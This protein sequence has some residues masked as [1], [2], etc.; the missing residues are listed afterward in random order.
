MKTNK[1]FTFVFACIPG[2][3]HMYLGMMKKGILL[4]SI[5]M[6]LGGITAFMGMGFFLSFLPV[7]WFYA[8]FDTYIMA[9]AELEE[10]RERDT[11][12]MESVSRFCNGSGV[13]F[14]EKRKKLLGGLLL[15]FA[16]YA[17]MYGFVLPVISNIGGDFWFI[18]RIVRVIPT[19]LVVFL[20]FAMGIHMMRSNNKEDFSQ[21]MLEENEEK[22]KNEE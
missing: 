8:F 18:R 7:I 6:G 19:L 21:F 4:M 17:L 3:G 15:F 13:Q 5:F 1:F 11:E 12:F 20:L 10:R 22:N 9:R 16:V 14:F 2:A